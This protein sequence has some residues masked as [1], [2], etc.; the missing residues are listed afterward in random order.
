MSPFRIQSR[1]NQLTSLLE[2]Y[3]WFY[4]E[5]VP[6]LF[7]VWQDRDGNGQVLIPLDDARP[8]F[9]RLL[10][11]AQEE[12]LRRFGP[13]AQKFKDLIDLSAAAALDQTKWEKETTVEAGLIPWAEGEALYAS[14]RAML[15]ASAKSTREVRMYHGN[16][17]AHIAK[18]FLEGCFMGQTAIGSFVITA[19]TPVEARFHAS[20]RSEEV[21][22]LMPRSS[23]TYSGRDIMETFERSL[24]LVRNGL[25]EYRRKPT[26]EIFVDAV[27]EGLSYEFVRALGEVTR[28]GEVAVRVDSFAA[29]DDV[30]RRKPEYVFNASEAP[31]LEQVAVRF[32]QPPQSA[33]VTLEGE[34]VLLSRESRAN[35]RVI[36]LIVESGANIKKAR[37]RLTAEQYE[38]ALFAHSNDYRL[39]VSGRLERE[40]NVFWLYDAEDVEAIPTEQ[41][42]SWTTPDLF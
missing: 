13:D 39:R 7:A 40:G 3:G 14:A 24:S 42:P 4:A 36:R 2:H 1:V 26:T 18:R 28:G 29:V 5:G 37:V 17:S 19:H 9:D 15:A 16:A 34:V 30:A 21:F 23:E 22:G 20:R 33:Q 38:K 27:P 31:V 12:I 25:D 11:A 35:I 41:G 8:D 10:G 32:A 6:G